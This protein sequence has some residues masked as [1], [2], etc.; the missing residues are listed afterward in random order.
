[1]HSTDGSR[2]TEGTIGFSASEPAGD[3][4]AADLSAIWKVCE[5][6][7]PHLPPGVIVVVKSTVPVGTNRQVYEKLK[8]LTGRE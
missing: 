4:G 8:A 6:L 7:A 2:G 1:L 3:D 5:A